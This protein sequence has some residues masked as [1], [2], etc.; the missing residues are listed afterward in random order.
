MKLHK[1]GTVEGTPLEIAEYRN[2]LKPEERMPIAYRTYRYKHIVGRDGT[3][4]TI[5]KR[6]K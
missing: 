5:T 3:L 1:D 6:L 2:S 4:N